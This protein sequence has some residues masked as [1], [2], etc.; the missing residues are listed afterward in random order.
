VINDCEVIIKDLKY[1]STKYSAFYSWSRVDYTIELNNR[2][3][4]FF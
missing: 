3:L 4:F 1:H 2:S